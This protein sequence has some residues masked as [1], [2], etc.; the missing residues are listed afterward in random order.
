[1]CSWPERMRPLGQPEPVRRG[2]KKGRGKEASEAEAPTL[3]SACGRCEGRKHSSVH[4]LSTLSLGQRVKFDLDSIT[5]FEVTPYSEVYGPHPSTFD[6][7]RFHQMVP[8]A[9]SSEESE[10]SLETTSPVCS[11]FE[12]I[13]RWR[14]KA[15]LLV[16]V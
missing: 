13:R 5:V 15:I 16:K 14:E 7:D 2:G 6:F 4:E 10:D 11:L 3:L 8:A 1:M 12:G 9:D